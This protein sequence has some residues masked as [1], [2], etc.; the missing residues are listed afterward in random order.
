MLQIQ[1]QPHSFKKTTLIK[2]KALFVPHT[3]IVGDFNTPLSLMDRSWKQKLNRDTWTLT[4][5][6]KQ[7][8]LIDIYR[9]FDPK[10]KGYTFFSVPQGTSSKID[11]IIGHKTGLHRYK[12]IEIIPCLLFDHQELR[13]IFNN[14]INNRKPTFTW[15]L[16]NNLLN[17]SLV[18]DEIK[19][20]IKDFLEFNE[21]E[22]TT[23]PN[24]WDTMKAVLRGKLIALGAS[25]KKLE[26]AYISS[27]TAHLE[28]K[29]AIHPRG[30]DSR[31]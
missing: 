24:L 17:D 3:I 20:E 23:Y 5:V 31:K 12:N 7:M 26:R 15:K 30:V 14:N 9:T 10:T 1:G 13:L 29:E 21:N 11:H 16:N 25:K 19:K 6:I 27:L 18:K 8:D 4:N 22:A 2:L 28:L